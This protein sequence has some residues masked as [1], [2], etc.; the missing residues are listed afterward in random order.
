M[1]D[2][3]VQGEVRDSFWRSKSMKITSLEYCKETLKNIGSV[4]KQPV[5]LWRWI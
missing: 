5:C 2:L 3:E 4:K 1:G